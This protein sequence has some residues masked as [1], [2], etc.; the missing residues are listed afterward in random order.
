MVLHN[1]GDIV[2]IGE[3]LAG[4]EEFVGDPLSTFIEN[5]KIYAATAGFVKVD[6]KTR[7]IKV[8]NKMENKRKLPQ[9]GDTVICVAEV[10][11]SHSVGCT[12]YKINSRLLT[13]R[14]RCAIACFYHESTIR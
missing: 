5:E 12:I 8:D 4:S 14:S 10:I 7:S 13:G 2:N 9:K 11:R 3:E 6:E 1:N